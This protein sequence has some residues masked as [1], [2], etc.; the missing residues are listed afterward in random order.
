MRKLQILK[1]A[2]ILYTIWTTHFVPLCNIKFSIANFD[3]TFPRKLATQMDSYDW[4]HQAVIQR[5]IQCTKKCTM[6]T[7]HI[8]NWVKSLQFVSQKNEKVEKYS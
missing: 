5:Q 4:Q 6:K 8:I 3:E 7:M 2:Q 1:C